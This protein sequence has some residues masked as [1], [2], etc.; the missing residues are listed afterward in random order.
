MVEATGEEREEKKVKYIEIRIPFIV[1][2]TE[3]VFQL[4]TMASSS[5]ITTELDKLVYIEMARWKLYRL[6]QKHDVDNFKLHHQG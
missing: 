3:K 2:S 5:R 6:Y 4:E 1:T